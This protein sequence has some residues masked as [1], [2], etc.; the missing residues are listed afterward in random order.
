MNC[1]KLYAVCP[2]CGKRLCKAVPGSELEQECPKCQSLVL[3]WVDP[4]G[5]VSVQISQNRAA[6]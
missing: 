5:K 3:V 2:A 6:S 4:D 1:S